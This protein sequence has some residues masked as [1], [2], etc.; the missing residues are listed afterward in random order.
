MLR[1]LPPPKKSSVNSE[2]RSYLVFAPG[3]DDLSYATDSQFVTY[4]TVQR[5]L[6]QIVLLLT[7]L[8]DLYERW[9]CKPTSQLLALFRILRVI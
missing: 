1:A 9:L 8:A 7:S 4:A 2:G 5:R 6:V 3:A